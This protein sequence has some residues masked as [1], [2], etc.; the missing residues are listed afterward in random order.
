MG[1]NL[2]ECQ[3]FTNFARDLRIRMRVWAAPRQNAE[4][5]ALGLRQTCTALDDGVMVTLQVLVLSFPVRIRVVQLFY[6]KS[7]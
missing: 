4:L 7:T 5:F 2:A 3:I 6:T 1:E